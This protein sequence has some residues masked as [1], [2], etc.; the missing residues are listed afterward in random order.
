LNYD[1]VWR[2]LK[3]SKRDPDPYRDWLDEL[4]S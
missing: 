3:P 2:A 4:I 1:I